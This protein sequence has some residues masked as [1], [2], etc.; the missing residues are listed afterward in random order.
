MSFDHEQKVKLGKEAWAYSIMM[1]RLSRL[2]FIEALIYSCIHFGISN[3]S[4]QITRLNELMAEIALSV[5]EISEEA[6]VPQI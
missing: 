3:D 4:D 2:F 1:S 6:G 5:H